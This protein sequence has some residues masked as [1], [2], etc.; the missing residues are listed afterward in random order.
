MRSHIEL[1]DPGVA[2][3]KYLLKSCRMIEISADKTTTVTEIRD[4]HQVL[5]NLPLKAD[6]VKVILDTLSGWGKEGVNVFSC[7]V[8]TDYPSR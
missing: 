1:D 6:T 3:P 2:M 8:P 5:L 7:D 4:N